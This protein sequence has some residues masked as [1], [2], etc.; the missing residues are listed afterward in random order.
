MGPPRTAEHKAGKCTIWARP[1]SG[2]SPEARGLLTVPTPHRPGT[3]SVRGK[4]ADAGLPRHPEPAAR[5]APKGGCQ[6]SGKRPNPAPPP[7]AARRSPPRPSPARARPAGP[8]QTCPASIEMQGPLLR[9]KAPVPRR[10]AWT[11][12]RQPR[13]TASPHSPWRLRGLVHKQQRLPRRSRP[14]SGDGAFRAPPSLAPPLD[15]SGFSIGP[16]KVS[17]GL[18]KKAQPAVCS[19]RG[20]ARRIQRSRE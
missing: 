3:L 1:S 20:G 9:S 8:A 4:V 16:L 7:T 11:A 15:G 6:V 19:G 13:P 14:P 17:R 5:D 10:K 18:G 12:T 2:A